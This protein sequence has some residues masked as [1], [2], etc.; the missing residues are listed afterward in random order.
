MTTDEKRRATFRELIV[1]FTVD[2]LGAGPASNA[3]ALQAGPHGLKSQSGAI[4]PVS[5]RQPKPRA[6]SKLACAP[7]LSLGSLIK[8][9][10]KRHHPST[11][12]TKE[13]P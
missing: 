1:A 7:M 8:S 10:Q 11:A 12:V 13:T 3:Q 9:V 5:G 2:E 4:Y 6:A